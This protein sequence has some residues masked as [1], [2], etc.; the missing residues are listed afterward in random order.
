[1]H[2]TSEQEAAFAEQMAANKPS[3]SS[4]LNCSATPTATSTGPNLS[5]PPPPISCSPSALS[6]SSSSESS[7]TELEDE[8]VLDEKAFSFDPKHGSLAKLLD[9]SDSEDSLML[10]DLPHSTDVAATAERGQK[11]ASVV[12]TDRQASPLELGLDV[13]A[14]LGQCEAGQSSC[15]MTL[16]N[17]DTL[18]DLRSYL[19]TSGDR[20]EVGENTS[21]ANTHRFQKLRLGSSVEGVRTP[22]DQVYHYLPAWQPDRLR[23]SGIS[24]SGCS[25][26]DAEGHGSD[27]DEDRFNY[28]GEDEDA[29]VYQVGRQCASCLRAFNLFRRRH[30]CRRC[31]HIFCASCCNHWQSVEGLAT[32]KAVRI[33]AECH[34]FL[35]VKTGAV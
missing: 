29:I 30:H 35:N 32:D 21:S 19:I 14:M 5:S 23:E 20:S 8:L 16:T 31:G 17:T 13:A 4:H 9:W 33:C 28:N 15:E 6:S 3:A 25:D 24:H 34:E 27:S 2:D 18:S 22:T 1:M 10:P 11:K 7:D 26:S 12:A